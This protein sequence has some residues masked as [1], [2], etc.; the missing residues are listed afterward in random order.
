MDEISITAENSKGT[1]AEKSNDEEGI[2]QESNIQEPNNQSL[3]ETDTGT[4]IS[5]EIEGTEK[6][7]DKTESLYQDDEKKDNSNEEETEVVTT[8]IVKDLME[9]MITMLENQLLKVK[10]DEIVSMVLHSFIDNIIETEDSINETMEHIL[11]TVE[12]YTSEDLFVLQ[13]VTMVEDS[14]IEEEKE[15]EEKPKT[16]EP[17]KNTSEIKNWIK[18]VTK[19]RRSSFE[20]SPSSS[21]QN[22]RVDSSYNLKEEPLYGEDGQ[23]ITTNNIRKSVIDPKAADVLVDIDEMTRKRNKVKEKQK[24]IL[25]KSQSEM[26]YEEEFK[27]LKE[28]RS[29]EKSKSFRKHDN[30]LRTVPSSEYV[31][32]PISL[33]ASEARLTKTAE[34]EETKEKDK[35]IPEMSSSTEDCDIN[36][37]KKKSKWFS[38]SA[39]GRRSST[40]NSTQ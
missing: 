28:T 1:V 19:V 29:M 25:S 12:E 4:G 20:S 17:D 15:E 23:P 16:T 27:K 14:G 18:S 21:Q 36:E 8:V 5:A 13:E 22:I 38:L 40:K 37:K 30:I 6:I 31:K 32:I 10:T 11:T 2:I 24:K 33:T 39:F 35:N 26:F 7:N 3:L 9:S 34:P